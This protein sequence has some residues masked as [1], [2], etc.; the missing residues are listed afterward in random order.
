MGLDNTQR[1]GKI[2]QPN[3]HIEMKDPDDPEPEEEEVPA[4]YHI[5]EGFS[6]RSFPIPSKI[7]RREAK[8]NKRSKLNP[9]IKKNKL[10]A[11]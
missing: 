7:L 9:F 6:N 1:F 2:I 8:K 4:G 3:F 11:N 10:L 5:E